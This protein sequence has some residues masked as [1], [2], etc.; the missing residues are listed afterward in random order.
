MLALAH[1]L[2][3]T[4]HPLLVLGPRGTGKTFLARWI[5]QRSA[6][7]G[8]FLERSASLPDGLAHGTLLGHRKGA[9]TG[10]HEGQAGYVEQA[11]NGTLFL[12]EIGAA[13]PPVQEALLTL[14]EG[15]QVIRLGDAREI[16]ID[17]RFIAATN[18]DLDTLT[19]SG[20]FRADLRDRF[21]PFVLP[22]PPLA[23]RRDEI[24]PLAAWFLAGAADEA[25]RTAPNPLSSS[26]RDLFMVA[27]WPGNVRGLKQACAFATA[28]AEPGEPIGVEHLPPGLADASSLVVRYER[29]AEGVRLALRDARGNRTQAAKF[30]GVTRQYFQELMKQHDV[31]DGGWE[32]AA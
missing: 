20:G 31:R 10:A 25:N 24:L 18:A 14:I 3:P 6:R 30:Y 16:P 15:V 9:Y 12:D 27:A 7:S 13:P 22:M 29:S 4:R 26:V 23:Q 32:P 28:M 21:G 5:H 1:R 19:E 11:R 2:A 8:P 17:V